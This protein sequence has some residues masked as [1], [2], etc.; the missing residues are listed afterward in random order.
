MAKKYSVCITDAPVA[1]YHPIKYLSEDFKTIDE[2]ES[3]FDELAK[4]LK[5]D[6]PHGF[7]LWLGS[8]DGGWNW[9]TVKDIVNW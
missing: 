6:Y 2:A 7:E 8:Y 1:E 9:S 4:N 3:R 5:N